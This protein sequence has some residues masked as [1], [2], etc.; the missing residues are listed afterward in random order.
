MKRDDDVIPAEYIQTQKT[1]VQVRHFQLNLL[2]DPLL[3][4]CLAMS[5]WGAARFPKI[6]QAEARG[7]HCKWDQTAVSSG[8]GGSKDLENETVA[9]DQQTEVAQGAEGNEA[10]QKIHLF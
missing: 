8:G 3:C 2:S 9:F 1:S 10:R 7:T 4:I 6:P 5:L